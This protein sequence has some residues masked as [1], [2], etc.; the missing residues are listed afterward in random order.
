[1]SMTPRDRTLTLIGILLALFL[2]AID[3]T[4]VAT[5]LPRIVEDLDGLSRYAWVA[6]AYL[7]A[8]TALVPIYGKLADTYSRKAIEIFSVSTFLVGS[9]LCGLAGEFGTL[10]LLGDGMNQLIFFRALQGIGGAGLFSMAF[11][12]IADLFPPNVRGRYQ[13]LVGATFGIASV[14]GPWIGGL[15][16]DHAGGFIQGVAGWRWVF[17]VNVPTGAVALWFLLTHMPPLRPSGDRKPLDALSAVLLV[18]G[19]VPIVLGLQLDKTAHPWLSL[20]T[21]GLLG[22]GLVVLTLFVVRSLTSRNPIL[23]LSLFRVRVFSTSNVA[24]FFL[25]AAFLSLIIFLPLFMV[26]VLGVSATRAGVSLI[27]LSLGLVFGSIV[28]GQ[29]VS[30]FG[31][32]RLFM[33]SGAVI[34]FAGLFLLS[35]M[36]PDITYWRV[37]LYM[38]IAGLGVG[39]SLPLYTLAIQNAVDGRRVGQATSASQFFRQ[40]GGTVGAAVMGTV[41]ATSLAAS[42]A[43]M[44]APAGMDPAAFGGGSQ[45]DTQGLDQVQIAIHDAFAQQYQV[46]AEAVRS[47]DPARLQQVVAASPMPPAARA[48]VLLGGNRAIQ[49]GAAAEDAFL[50]QIRT[51]LDTQAAAVAAEVTG[52]IKTAFATAITRIYRYLLAVVVLGFIATLFV[53]VLRLRT[54][55]D[56][57]PA[58]ALE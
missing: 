47:G 37:T 53:P 33:L 14:I 42:F 34:L 41:L 18:G 17:Y 3:Q 43:G 51:Q 35:R 25:G 49:G 44:Q 29:L 11:I 16:T 46:L 22:G 27:P 19:L 9:A 32:Y 24:L 50:G 23:D 26:N 6:T 7:L 40:I 28:A 31:R 48:I 21:L 55:N 12:I 52:A 56:P 54:S 58:V 20:A 30:A 45:V 39:P 15:L 38:V 10:P 8:S 57:H 36:T 2:G 4:I 13:G 1:M 5:A